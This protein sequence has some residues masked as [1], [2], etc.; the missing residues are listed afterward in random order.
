MATTE[1]AL[2]HSTSPGPP[3]AGYNHYY[4]DTS[5][6]LH[7]ITPAGVDSILGAAGLSG[8]TDVVITSPVNG[9]VLFYNGAKWV[10]SSSAGNRSP[11][12]RLFLHRNFR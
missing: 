11:A 3:A 9:Q 4:V 7:Q 10:N 5:G 6:N 2:K 8:L 12:T 1:L